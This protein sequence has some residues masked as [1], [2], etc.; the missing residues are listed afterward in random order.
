MKRGIDMGKRGE[1]KR[2]IR[3]DKKWEYPLKLEKEVAAEVKALAL[4]VDKS[5]GEVLEKLIAAALSD[6][7]IMTAIYAMWPPK[8][9]FVIVRGRDF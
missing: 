8:D 6:Q 7:E 1:V 9:I 4:N 2:K 5:Y 3:S